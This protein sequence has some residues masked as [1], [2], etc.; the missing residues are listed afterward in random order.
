MLDIRAVAYVAPV[1]E[2]DFASVALTVRIVNCADEP[3]LVTG[4]F[5]VYNDNTGTLVHTSEIVPFTLAAGGTYDA[6]A[7]TDYDPPAP[8]DDT[9]FVLFDGNACNALVPDGIGLH[10]GAFYFDVKPTGMGPAPAAHHATHEDGGSDEIDVTGLSGLLADEQDPL[11]HHADHETGGSDEIDVTGLP[12][13][14]ADEQDPLPHY[15]DKHLGIFSQSDILNG[16]LGLEPWALAALSSGTLS[17][18]A[19]SP[20]HPGTSALNS[21]TSSTSGARISLTAAALSLS[22]SETTDFILRPQTLTGTTI[23]LGF[24]DTLTG[25]DQVDGA[26]IEMAQ[27]GGVDGVI[28]GKTASNSVRSTTG[29]NYTLVTNTWYRLK[30]AV[31]SDATRVDFYLYSEAGALLWTD[32]LTTNIPTAAGRETG[33]GI[34]ATNSGTTAVTLVD[35][36][37][38][39]LY[40]RRTL[41]R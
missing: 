23:R 6:S 17:N 38:V 14:L 26:Y 3:G 12:G 39:E 35:I 16:S 34:V 30:I 19:A 28:V 31:N 5:R 18:L 21:S 40:I 7:L 1:A 8:A 9:Y 24:L 13:L 10:L 15:H 27:V 20:N 41:V 37:Y 4:T 2:V 11:A 25:S 22:G 32:N 33:H 36:D 29:T